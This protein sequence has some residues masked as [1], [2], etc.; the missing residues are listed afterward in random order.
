MSSRRP[1][2]WTTR[3]NWI[4]DAMVFL[5]AVLAALSGLYFLY[6]VSG[7][8][9][10]GRNPTYGM[11][12]LVERTTWDMLHTWGGILMISAA[13]IHLGIHL[14]W[15]GMMS[16]KMMAI[17][18]GTSRGL[19]KGAK[20]NLVVDAA[21]AISFVLCAG[22]GVFFLFAP[23]GGFQGGA[24][25]GWDPMFLFG[26]STW[27]LIHTW[28]GVSLAVAAVIHLAIHWRWITKVSARM[29]ERRRESASAEISPA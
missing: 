20:I 22:S 23:I 29:L 17:F 10:G 15:I 4:L 28:S 6:F 26:R 27:D 1:L 16:R 9:Q 5:G 11:T 18:R 8:Y 25:P 21:I 24:N 12:F 13:L 14:D 2:S 19:S 3:L 7:G